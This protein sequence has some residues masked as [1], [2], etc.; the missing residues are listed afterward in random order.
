M[1]MYIVMISLFFKS[2]YPFTNFYTHPILLYSPPSPPP[3]PQQEV[4]G[5]L[6]NL[7]T[8]DILSF[9]HVMVLRDVD[10]IIRAF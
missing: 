10:D 4:L 3:S 7:A 5:T 9:G 1:K 8:V 6:I 2:Y